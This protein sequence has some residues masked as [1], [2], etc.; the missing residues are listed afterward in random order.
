M[1]LRDLPQPVRDFLK[2]DS[3][4]RE[5]IFYHPTFFIPFSENSK[6]QDIAKRALV[7]QVMPYYK[8]RGLEANTAPYNF[9]VE[10]MKNA[11]FHG[12]SK[13]FTVRFELFLTP[14]ALAAS[15]RDGGPYFTRQEVK[16]AWENRT[17]LFEPHKLGGTD[18]VY[19]LADLIHVDTATGTLY[20]GWM[21]KEF[22]SPINRDE[23]R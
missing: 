20:T 10:P 2:L 5:E 21:A 17:F 22:C 19:S 23:K 15:F 18:I 14:L 8:N 4:K 13:S 1:G 3:Y 6:V 11:N 7:N 16:E 12:G 9:L